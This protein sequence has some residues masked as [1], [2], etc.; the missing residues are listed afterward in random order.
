[1]LTRTLAGLTFS[2]DMQDLSMVCPMLRALPFLS[3]ALALSAVGCASAPDA[4]TDAP[5]RMTPKILEG[6]IL[7]GDAALASGQPDLAAGLYERAYESQPSAAGAARW[8]RAM[9]SGGHME[10]AVVAL[11]AANKRFPDNVT[12]LTEL[13]RCAA[14]GG[15]KDEANAAFTQVVALPGA[16]WAAFMASGSFAA[17]TG[18]PAL[19]TAL[20][21][22]AYAV[23]VDERE[24]YST[25]ANMA[26]LRA[27]TG[28]IS[29]AVAD[30]EQITAH[31][32]VEPKVHAD[33]ALL[34]GL[35]GNQDGYQRQMEE[36]NLQTADASR[37]GAWLNPI[38]PSDQSEPESTKP[39]T[40]SRP[41][42]RVRKHVATLAPA[43]SVFETSMPPI[44]DAGS[45][46]DKD[47]TVYRYTTPSTP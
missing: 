18:Q 2:Q 43:A 10:Q 17:T 28:D 29:G 31:P 15:Y 33:L 22:R 24:Q 23:A 8:A 5:T 36:A 42:V 4:Y 37:I 27:Q 21:K 39:K 47:I 9:R 11:Q 40:N 12:L 38:P 7:S 19:A 41:R 25:Q 14:D 6:A 45:S 35:Q 32:G 44:G 34:Y 16:D 3:L 26:M 46:A 1:M 20:F 13:G 30:L